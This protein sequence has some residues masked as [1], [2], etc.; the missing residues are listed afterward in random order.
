MGTVLRQVLWQKA[1]TQLED[2]NVQNIP[3]ETLVFQ[4][5]VV[6]LCMILDVIL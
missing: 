1:K 6:V 2:A 5:V 3:K 4:G